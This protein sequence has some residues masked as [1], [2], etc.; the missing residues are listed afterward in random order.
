MPYPAPL[1]GYPDHGL[2]SLPQLSENPPN[3]ILFLTNLPE[4]TNELMLS[5]LFTQF[6]GFKEAHLVPGC[7]DIAFVEFDNEV[8][9]GAARDVLQ[10]F[11]IT[12]NNAMK[13]SLAKK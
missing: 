1:S 7:H 8:Q 11:K 12:Q 9:A 4:E 6:P 5:M 3:H 10:G 2:P 13:I